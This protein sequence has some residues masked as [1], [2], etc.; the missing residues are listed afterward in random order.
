MVWQ[1][2]QGPIPPTASVNVGRAL[3]FEVASD[4]L[5]AMAASTISKTAIG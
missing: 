3:A 2:S 4:A 5:R 1:L